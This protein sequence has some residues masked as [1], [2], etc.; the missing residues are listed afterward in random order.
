M[1]GGCV[2][3]R[4]LA[5]F[6]VMVIVI[7]IMR[8]LKVYPALLRA[9]WERAA[10]YR[11]VF[12]VSLLNAIFPLVMMSIWIGM[13]QDGPVAGYEA[14]DFA[15][16]YLAAVLVRRI[17]GVGIAQDVERLILTGELSVYLIRPLDPLHYFF[18]RVLAGRVVI[19]SMVFVPVA[20]A[21]LAVPSAQFD[22]RPASLALFALACVIGLLFEFVAQFLLSGLS[23]WIIQTHGLVAAYQFVKAFFGGYIVPL[24]LFPAGISTVLLWLPFQSSVALPVEILTGRLSPEQSALRLGV[25][26][27]WVALIAVGG[28][29]LWQAGLRDYSAVGA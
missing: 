13:A 21:V 24:A 25:S 2:A 16:Y 7:A 22:L 9:A 15:G 10:A 29:L 19:V 6:I 23:F 20:L 12:A 26:A 27:V 14:T 28:R 8:I 3:D 11:A 18:A 5:G 1:G 4:S 17:T